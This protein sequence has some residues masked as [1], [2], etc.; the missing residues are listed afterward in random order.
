MELES[1]NDIWNLVRDYCKD[2]VSDTIYSLWLEPLK[3]VSFEE[4]R[5]VLSASEFKAQIVRGKFLNLLKE[6]FESVMGFSVDVEIVSEKDNVKT[7]VAPEE[8]KKAFVP[9]EPVMNQ[10]AQLTFDRFVVGS[11]NKFAYA[12]A[13]AVAT[14]PGQAYNPLFIYGNSGLGKTHL[15]H[16]ICAE[17]KANKP[18]AKIINTGGED[19]TNE[20]ISSIEN[21]SMT[22]FHEKYRTADILL[23]DDIQFIAGKTQTQ[24]EFFHTFNALVTDNKQIV[25]TSDRPPK[26]I[27]RLEDRIKTRFEW[28]LLADIQPPDIETRMAIIKRKAEDYNLT[29]SDDVVQYIA[30]KLKNNIRQLEGAVN[31]INAYCTLS[32]HE[33]TIATAQKAIKDI[34]NENQPVAVTV[35]KILT[36]VSRAYGVTVENITSQKK[37]AS[38]SEARQAAMYI[39]REVTSLSME[40]I[41]EAF[42]GR[43][44]STVLYSI[45]ECEKHMAENPSVKTTVQNII[46]NINANS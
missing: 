28:G 3:L 32:G 18:N 1:Y 11:S 30:E 31:R 19:F 42:G 44:H 4:T 26:E 20:L 21:K 10:A 17:I 14:A 39:I 25:L 8:N 41:G 6:A 13:Q 33:P 43:H 46:N 15:L 27:P 12:A 22:Q 16:A 29:L 40:K 7:G 38:V 9:E 34:G 36:E 37:S 2:K 24:E 45:S 5:V 35:D 23:I